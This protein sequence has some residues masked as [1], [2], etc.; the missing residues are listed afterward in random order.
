MLRL[1][2]L[3]LR[4]RGTLTP[5]DDWPEGALLGSACHLEAICAGVLALAT[6]PPLPVAGTGVLSLTAGAGDLCL[7][8]G[9]D[10]LCLVTGMDDLLPAADAGNLCPAAGA[11]DLRSI[12]AG[13]GSASDPDVSLAS[14]SVTV[15]SSPP[16]P[17]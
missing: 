3:L 5:P 10:A 11:G 12:L 6:D 1:P 4:A 13:G 17:R 16:A 9:I 2:V 8:P 15:T 7:A 14:P